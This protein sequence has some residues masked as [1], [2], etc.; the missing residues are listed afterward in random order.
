MTSKP[1]NNPFGENIHSPIKG[2][3]TTKSRTPS[4]REQMPPPASRRVPQAVNSTTSAT[5]HKMH[6]QETIQV[7]NHGKKQHTKSKQQHAFQSLDMNNANND[8]NS[9]DYS[10]SS[11]GTGVD[12]NTNTNNQAAAETSHNISTDTD[13]ILA[14]WKRERQNNASNI[15]HNSSG[16]SIIPMV[17]NI[18]TTAAKQNDS[19][20]STLSAFRSVC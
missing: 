15:S 20:L 12:T 7:S 18:N 13:T 8:T 1:I 6:R 4:S 19:L 9:L 16:S 11:R 10:M 14:N 3:A 5:R 17:N 2:A